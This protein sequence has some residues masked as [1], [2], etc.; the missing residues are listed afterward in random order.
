MKRDL[1]LPED[2]NSSKT[3]ARIIQLHT[4][5]IKMKSKTNKNS[6]KKKK[7]L[8]YSMPIFKA[9]KYDFF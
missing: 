9:K 2:L 5:V 7:M 4:P 1:Y 8:F 6:K 3:P